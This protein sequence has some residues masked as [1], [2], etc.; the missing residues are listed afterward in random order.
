MKKKLRDMGYKVKSF[1]IYFIV[2]FG[3]VYKDN[4]GKA[5]FKERLR[6]FLN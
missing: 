4:K 3:R 6:F 5:L 2:V 1:S